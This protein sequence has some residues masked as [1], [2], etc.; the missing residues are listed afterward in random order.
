MEGGRVPS[1]RFTRTIT[2][3]TAV[4]DLIATN[5]TDFAGG[6]DNAQNPVKLVFTVETQAIRYTEHGTNPSS[7]L[8]LNVPVGQTVTILGW[9]NIKRLRMFGAAASA[10]VNYTVYF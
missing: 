4:F 3:T 2:V 7:T 10:A 6:T 5:P 9:D 1:A 8:G